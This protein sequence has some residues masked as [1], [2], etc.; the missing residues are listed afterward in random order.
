MLTRLGQ[1]DQHTTN[2][3]MIFYTEIL[4]HQAGQ[5]IGASVERYPLRKSNLTQDQAIIQ[6]NFNQFP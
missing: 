4:K 6:H 2:L 1:S 5:I 3:R